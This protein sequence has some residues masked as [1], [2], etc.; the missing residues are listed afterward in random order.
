M[1]SFWVFDGEEEC[2][3]S[4]FVDFFCLWLELEPFFLLWSMMLYCELECSLLQ[5]W[6]YCKIWCQNLVV[7]LREYV[8]L[9]VVGML[10]STTGK[11]VWS[12]KEQAQ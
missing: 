12:L 4:S 8:G 3:G 6:C 5:D 10:Y 11:R 9:E 7:Y 2:P 1:Q